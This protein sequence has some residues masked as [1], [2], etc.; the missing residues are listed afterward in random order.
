ALGDYLLFSAPQA[1]AIPGPTTLAQRNAST[2]TE[3]FHQ[4]PWTAGGGAGSPANLPMTTTPSWAQVELRQVD[5]VVTLTINNTNI[6][7]YTNCTQFTHGDIMVGYDD[8]F[9]SIGSG[10]G[11][12]VIYDNVRV[13]NLGGVQPENIKITSIMMVGGSVQMDFTVASGRPVS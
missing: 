8:S 9:N 12:L 3:V 4:P 7:S 2:L 5:G 11:G 13:I 10:G 1:G 6:F